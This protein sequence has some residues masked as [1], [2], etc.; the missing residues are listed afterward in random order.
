MIFS[1][2]FLALSANNTQAGWLDDI[3]HW[4]TGTQDLSRFEEP[5]EFGIN[6]T[7]RLVSYR[8][9]PEC[10]LPWTQSNEF[11]Q[12]WDF[13]SPT[14]LNPAAPA[15]R[16]HLFTEI[17]PVLVGGTHPYSY[18]SILIHEGGTDLSALRVLRVEGLNTILQEAPTRDLL[19]NQSRSFSVTR[20]VEARGQFRVQFSHA[21]GLNAAARTFQDR[22]VI[23]DFRID[24]DLSNSDRQYVPMH[25]SD[26]NPCIDAEVSIGRN[27]SRSAE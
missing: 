8:H 22:R 17:G 12:A 5:L 18:P 24:Y 3:Y 15:E 2:I 23:S 7:V 4:V 21:V 16:F 14:L 9:S 6:F 13:D 26:T 11:N 19:I 27:T 25:F 20:A 10:A 1:L